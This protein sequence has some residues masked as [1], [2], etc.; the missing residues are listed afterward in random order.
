MSGWASPGPSDGDW[1]V[2]GEADERGG[3][4]QTSTH[5]S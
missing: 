5:V 3:K 2:P 4:P 1:L